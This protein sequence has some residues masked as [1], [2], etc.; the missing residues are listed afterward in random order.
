MNPLKRYFLR[1]PVRTKR[2]M[3]LLPG[4]S[5]WFLILFP[6]WGSLLI[7]E[8]VAVYIIAYTIYWLYKSLSVALLAIVGNAQ[9][10][11]SK[12]FDWMGDVAVF[13]DWEKV[14]HVV[15]IPTFQE[16]LSTLR[17]SLMALTRQTFPRSRIHVILSFEAREGPE[18]REKAKTLKREFVGV[19]GSIH[20][21][22]HP[23]IQGEV[24]GKSSN[25]SWAARTVIEPVLI[26][27]KLINVD[28][29]TITSQ[30]ADAQFHRNYFAALTYHFLDHPKRY[31]RFWQPA[32]TFYN[33]IWQIPAPI[34]AL[35]TVW[36]VVHMYLL[37]RHDRLV[38]FST[39][40]L[41]LALLQRIGYW[42][43]DVIPE[44]YR[45]FFKAFFS[46][47]GKV[48]VEPIFLPVN[49]DAA[50][51]TTFWKTM[52]NQYEQVKRWA[53][54]VSD[55]SYVIRN[56]VLIEGIPFWN[57]AFR[58]I[59]LVE[60]HFLWPVNWFALTI[61]ALLP[62]LLNPVFSRTVIGKTL[63][64]VSSGILTISLVALVAV[65]Y[66]D[67]RHR[68]KRPAS[69]SRLRRLLQPLEYILLPVVG[70]FF[71]ALPGLDAHTRLMLGRYLEYRVT[72][73]VAPKEIS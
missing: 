17:R 51:S 37:V 29:T 59:R 9:I 73:K 25:S 65:L 5:S 16:P 2:A 40:S 10:Q 58:L 6:I 55:D 12:R 46:T 71:N 72:E 11:A 39:Y 42:D 27:R 54:G 64:Q 61:G 28:Y 7:P 8:V 67:A 47:K 38:N 50:Q 68:P 23:D 34:R 15:V 44:D 69:Y 1:H 35:V 56:A 30:D 57:R 62:P 22:Y 52:V 20:V 60:D 66:I 4:M 43:T 63:P 32:V 31:E 33:N 49:M 18:A 53:W 21:T 36:S 41:S 24:K 48:E 14:H 3:E 26:R 70:L 19:F 45:I 13:P